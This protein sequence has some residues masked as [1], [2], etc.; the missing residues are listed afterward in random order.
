MK[1]PDNYRCALCDREVSRVTRHHIIPRSEGGRQTVDLCSACHKT[2]HGFF[3]NETLAKKLS[4]IDVLRQ[5]PDIGRYLAW[6]RRQPDRAIR[7]RTR[8]RKR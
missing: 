7:V 6:V 1:E 3:T 2:L 8:S 4:S 5:D